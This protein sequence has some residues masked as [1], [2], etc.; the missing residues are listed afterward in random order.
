MDFVLDSQE[1]LSLEN[2]LLRKEP[3]LLLSIFENFEMLGHYLNDKE[4]IL[5]VGLT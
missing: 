5:K 2:Q 1:S 4:N 3:E